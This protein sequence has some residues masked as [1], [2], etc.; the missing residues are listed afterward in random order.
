LSRRNS[1]A[2]SAK[3]SECLP[4]RGI[5]TA[6]T[7][8]TRT[9]GQTIGAGLAGAI[10]NFGLSRYAPDAIEALDLPL[11]ANRR[12]SLDPQQVAQMVEAVAGSLHDVYVV[13]AL[14]VSRLLP[15]CCCRQV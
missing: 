11:N 3:R 1:A 6:S 12:K 8:F 14:L 15:R 4:E 7:L 10:L 9:I 2:I 5:A 13:A